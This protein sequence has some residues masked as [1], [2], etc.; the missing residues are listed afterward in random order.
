MEKKLFTEKI[1]NIL[2]NSSTSIHNLET[3]HNNLN[4]ITSQNLDDL[5]QE[6]LK[7]KIKSLESKN[8]ELDEELFSMK[9]KYYVQT[10]IL[11]DKNT[12]LSKEV[13]ESQKLKVEF[14]KLNKN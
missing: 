6:E 13:S 8:K 1:K 2:I 9:N 7:T 12:E 11:N 4:T 5:T 3:E 14:D 10:K